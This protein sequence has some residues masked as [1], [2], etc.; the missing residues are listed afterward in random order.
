[1]S[2]GKSI[3][4]AV[5]AAPVKPARLICSASEESRRALALSLAATVANSYISLR[6]LDNQLDIARR[7]P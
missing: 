1:M 5:C 3:S 6:D 7:K 2:A 4:S